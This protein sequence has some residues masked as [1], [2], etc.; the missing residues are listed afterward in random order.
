MQ[1]RPKLISVI[2][3]AQVNITTYPP[4]AEGHMKRMR[5]TIH[6][7]TDKFLRSPLGRDSLLK[8]KKIK[9]LVLCSM[10]KWRWR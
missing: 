2:F 6:V 8:L 9:W 3:A 10:C 7:H 1:E 5:H 4:I